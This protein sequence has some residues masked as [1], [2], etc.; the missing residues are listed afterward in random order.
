MDFRKKL[1]FIKETKKSKSRDIPMNET[2]YQELKRIYQ[3]GKR[4]G[5][6]FINPK[7][8]K[9]FVDAPKS[10]YDACRRAGIKNLLLLFSMIF[11]C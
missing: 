8:G 9:A 7:T 2:V 3:N 5:L 11:I 4:Y 1:L 10:F 6:V